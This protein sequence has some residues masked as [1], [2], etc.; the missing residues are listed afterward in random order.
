M[1]TLWRDVMTV[2]WCQK[3]II[4]GEMAAKRPILILRQSRLLAATPSLP[5]PKCVATSKSVQA[6]EG[7]R[8]ISR[9]VA[10]AMKVQAR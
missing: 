2:L 5:S 3:E 9:R 8:L 10:E 6:T 1:L 7:P 4:K